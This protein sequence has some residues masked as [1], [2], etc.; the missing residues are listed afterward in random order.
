MTVDTT[1]GC[2]PTTVKF[3]EPTKSF[4]IYPQP[5]SNKLSFNF[6][7]VDDF[8]GGHLYIFDA[9]GKCVYKSIIENNLFSVELNLPNGIFYAFVKNESGTINMKKPVIILKD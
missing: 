1:P 5:A 4:I 2:I 8:R 6:G 7:N 9:F 3:L